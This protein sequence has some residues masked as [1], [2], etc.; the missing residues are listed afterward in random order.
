MKVKITEGELKH[1]IEC[2]VR[3]HLF[4]DNEKIIDQLNRPGINQAEIARHLIKNVW[5]DMD[6]DTA[7]SLLSK[8][9]RGLIS[10]TDEEENIIKQALNSIVKMS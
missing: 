9:A 7:R 3:K 6:E 1:I 4:E 2:N 5:S 8:K 10:I